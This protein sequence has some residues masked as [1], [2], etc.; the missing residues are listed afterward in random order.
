METII[1]QLKN[2]KALKLLEELEQLH[3]IRLLHKK[4]NISKRRSGKF[5]GKLSEVAAGKLHS[6]IAQS[7][8]EWER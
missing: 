7:R 6:E 4:R 8:N 5:A 2:K 1:I 3:L